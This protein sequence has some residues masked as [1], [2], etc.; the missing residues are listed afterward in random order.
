MWI[1]AAIEFSCYF[2]PPQLSAPAPSRPP[3]RHAAQLEDAEA[4]AEPPGARA[5]V[6]DL[7]RARPVGEV[8]DSARVPPLDHA[9][10][11]PADH[12]SAGRRGLR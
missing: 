6:G 3:P 8:V 11:P 12:E 4:E 1:K 7:W 9:E 5:E 10:P 2:S